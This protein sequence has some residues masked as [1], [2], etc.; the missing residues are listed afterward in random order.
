MGHLLSSQRHGLI[1][2]SLEAAEVLRDRS[3]CS[4]WDDEL[5][6]ML[7]EEVRAKLTFRSRQFFDA[8]WRS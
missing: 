4:R 2:A 7:K 6:S 1:F 8:F 3:R 5:A